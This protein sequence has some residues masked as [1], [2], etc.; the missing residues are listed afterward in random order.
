[1]LVPHTVVAVA[2]VVAQV[3]VLVSDVTMD[4]QGTDCQCYTFVEPNSE[5]EHQTYQMVVALQATAERFA[6]VGTGARDSHCVA[7]FEVLLE[8]L[9]Y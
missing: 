3:L 6:I 5:R 8:P 4:Y 9:K 7:D 1:M 2:A